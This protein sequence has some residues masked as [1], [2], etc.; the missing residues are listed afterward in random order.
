[1]STSPLRE[2]SVVNVGLPAFGQAVR[3]QDASALD[4]D[5]RPP[6]GGD[7]AAVAAL[8]ALWGVHGDAITQA[9]ERALLRLAEVL[10]QA[11]DVRP[12]R[13]VLPVL[14]EGRT[15]IHSGPPITPNRL[16]DP[17][18]RALVAACLFEKG[19]KDRR[20]RTRCSTP[21]RS[22][23]HRATSTATSGR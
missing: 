2:V 1:M 15:L 16:C 11:V 19:A 23:S 3:D 8:A 4:V 5:W 7:A 13:E 22:R 6:A 9:N 12:A 10:P 18:R 21:G 17:Q 20:P 14:S